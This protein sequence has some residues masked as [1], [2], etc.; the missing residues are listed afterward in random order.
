MLLLYIELRL[1]SLSFPKGEPIPA[2]VDRELEVPNIFE[3]PM[4]SS[5]IIN[6]GIVIGIL[7]SIS[8]R[9]YRST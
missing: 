3:S 5:S 4:M 9:R 6:G 1:L 7:T 8:V 2:I